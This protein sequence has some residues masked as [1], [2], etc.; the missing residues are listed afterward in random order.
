MCLP[1]LLF[2][3]F[4]RVCVFVS[5]HV[6]VFVSSHVCVCVLL[7]I[8][9]HKGHSVCHRTCVA[10]C[11]FEVRVRAYV[12]VKVHVFVHVFAFMVQMKVC[13][14][15]FDV[16]DRGVC[17]CVNDTYA[18]TRTRVRTHTSSWGPI[19]PPPRIDLCCCPRCSPPPALTHTCRF[20]NHN[21]ENDCAVE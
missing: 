1:G 7:S 18:H 14:L 5:S 10:A 17:V 13:S 21:G 20:V 19:A 6:C 15:V 3:V 4:V 9:Y 16:Y 8:H 11:M 12:R 2:G